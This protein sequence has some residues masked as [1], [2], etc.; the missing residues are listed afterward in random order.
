MYHIG[1][2]NM[3]KAISLILLAIVILTACSD[4]SDS[5]AETN[6]ELLWNAIHELEG[7]LDDL[8]KQ[9][10]DVE[11]DMESITSTGFSFGGG[12]TTGDTTQ[13]S[14]DATK[15]YWDYQKKKKEP[16]E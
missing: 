6:D 13:E 8:E 16:E 4:S 9:V 3:W 1:G 12:R 5:E 14:Q 15:A 2:C 11:N 7:R 10:G